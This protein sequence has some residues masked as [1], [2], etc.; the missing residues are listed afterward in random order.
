MTTLKNAPL[1]VRRLYQLAFMDGFALLGLVL[2]AVP[3]KRWADFP[4]AVKILGPIHGAL[5]IMLIITLIIAVSKKVITKP[6]GT[7]IFV[8]AFIPFGAFY[9][10]YLLKKS[11][12]T[13]D[14]Q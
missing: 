2:I 10:D 8:L 7:L 3:L 5:F 13:E 4:W 9:A 6:L 1:I 12:P 14:L 11:Q